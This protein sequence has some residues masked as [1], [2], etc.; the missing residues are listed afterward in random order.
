MDLIMLDYDMNMPHKIF[1]STSLAISIHKKAE[2]MNILVPLDPKAIFQT[3]KAAVVTIINIPYSSL[4]DDLTLY[5]AGCV[6]TYQSL[7]VLA[8]RSGQQDL[9]M[10]IYADQIVYGI[11]AYVRED[12][13]SFNFAF[14]ACVEMLQLNSVFG[15]LM[16]AAAIF[17]AHELIE[18]IIAENANESCDLDENNACISSNI[19]E[20]YNEAQAQLFD[21]CQ[22][23][24]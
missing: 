9:R 1:L 18:R 7:R 20:R 2:S 21:Y 24:E 6:I 8:E 10:Y 4:E 16:I 3:D 17:Y 12:I 15:R 19:W 14:N 22:I 13:D 23:N 11:L 5:A